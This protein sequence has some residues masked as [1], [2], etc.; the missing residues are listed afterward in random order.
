MQKQCIQ[1]EYSIKNQFTFSNCIK[2]IQMKKMESP[3]SPECMPWAVN[4]GCD[5]L[6]E[7][8]YFAIFWR[9]QGCTG[10]GLVLQGWILKIKS[11]KI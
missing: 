5:K 9:E 3:N 10:L 4:V 2:N 1:E 11:A 8:I 7:T 6:F